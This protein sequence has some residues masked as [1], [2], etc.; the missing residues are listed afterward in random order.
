MYKKIYLFLFV[1]FLSCTSDYSVYE[2]KG[3]AKINYNKKIISPLPKSTLLKVTN[4]KNKKSVVVTTNDISKNL[5]PRIITLPDNIFQELKLNK[6]LPLIH[7][8]TLR[9]NKVFIAKKTEI[10]EQEKRVDKKVVIEKINIMNLAN[11]KK[12]KDSIYLN[13]G[14]FYNKIY[15]NQLYKILKLR[16]NNKKLVFKDYQDKNYII[17]IGPLKNLTEFDKFYLKLGKIG[18]IGFDIKIQ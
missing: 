6:N 12:S 15:A 13:F 9:K 8:Q 2:R 10:Y 3:F 17:S 14:P 5:G 18:L 11:D 1:I 7:M 4:I 16:F